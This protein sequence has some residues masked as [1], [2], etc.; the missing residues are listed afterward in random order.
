MISF[1]SL[2]PERV[3][4]QMSTLNLVA[5]PALPSPR[6]GFIECGDAWCPVNGVR[7]NT[8]CEELLFLNCVA[9]RNL[10]IH[11]PRCGWGVREN[12]REEK[13]RRRQEA[14]ERNAPQVGAGW[15]ALQKMRKV[16]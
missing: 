16:A 13:A 12:S 14:R 15:K 8:Y 10:L 4:Q 1:S 9:C 6:V 11:D 5:V 7:L 2:M 3:K